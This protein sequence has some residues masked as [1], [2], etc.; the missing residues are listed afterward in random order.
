MKTQ[1]NFNRLKNIVFS[2]VTNSDEMKFSLLGQPFKSYH[3]K[4]LEARKAIN[5]LLDNMDIR[6][7]EC[8]PED[9]KKHFPDWYRFG[10]YRIDYN[11]HN[12]LDFI[13]IN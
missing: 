3:N 9:V 2:V 12:N 5:D 4:Q 10:R 11:R 13:K 1:P 8:L 6:A 7:V